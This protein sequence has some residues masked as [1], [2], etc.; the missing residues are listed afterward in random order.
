MDVDAA[1][2]EVVREIFPIPIV[3]VLED[4]YAVNIIPSYKKGLI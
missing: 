4:E 1:L 2:F 3:G